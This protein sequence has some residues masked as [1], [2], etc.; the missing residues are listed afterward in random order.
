M[1]GE[2]AQPY[3]RQLSLIMALD[4]GLQLAASG[5]AAALAIAAHHGGLSPLGAGRR[6][7]LE[8]TTAALH[9]AACFCLSQRYIHCLSPSYTAEAGSVVRADCLLPPARPPSTRRHW[10]PQTW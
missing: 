10:H 1:F 3:D 7:A 2:S 5:A 4:G 9:A 6:R 8:L